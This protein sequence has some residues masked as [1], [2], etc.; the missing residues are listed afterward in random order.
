[1]P[2]RVQKHKHALVSMTKCSFVGQ[3]DSVSL[4]PLTCHYC[5]HVIDSP[6]IHC[7]VN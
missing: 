2:L 6:N 5:A 3:N 7:E 4:I 1:M